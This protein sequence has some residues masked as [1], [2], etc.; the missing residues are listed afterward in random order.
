MN[1]MEGTVEGGMVNLG[2]MKLGLP[3]NSP[4]RNQAN[5]KV[6][7][8]FRP[9]HIFDTTA[10]CP[11][12][13]TSENTFEATVDVLEKL[14]P[15]DTAYLVAGDKNLIASLDP[16]SRIEM[17]RMAKFVVDVDRIQVFDAVTE[18]AIR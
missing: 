10:N 4:V 6:I 16:A 17:G 3:A 1:F 14:G 5:L 11:I 15:E 9:E 13:M 7:I 2:S 12:P 8:G 18:Q